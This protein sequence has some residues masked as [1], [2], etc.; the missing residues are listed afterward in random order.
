MEK[1]KRKII[2]LIIIFL[3]AFIGG[4]INV[5][6]LLTSYNYSISHATGNSSKLAEAYFLRDFQKFKRKI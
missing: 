1:R 4:Y 2:Q 6:S 3:L 5:F